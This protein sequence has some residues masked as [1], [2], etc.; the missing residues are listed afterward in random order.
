MA[1]NIWL[2]AGGEGS[3]DRVRELVEQGTSP[4]AFDDNSYSPLHAAASWG[5]S[6][7]LRFLVS[8]GG[9]INLAD[10][11]G[12][13]PLYVVE[14]I[15]MAKLVV[16]LGAD[17]RHVNEEGLT[18][19]AVL[20]E[21]HPHIALYLRTLTGEPSPSSASAPLDPSAPAPAPGQPQPNLDAPTDALMQA[22]RAI[23]ERS[24]R[25]DISEQE[26]DD[27]LREV[28]EQAVGGQ[29]E[30]GRAIGEQ[31]SVDDEQAGGAHTR[32]RTAD[33]MAGEQGKPK[34]SRDQDDIG[35]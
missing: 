26:T 6:D 21:E 8:N 18:A 33:E 4:N 2:A 28:V 34:R 25:G 16:D 1:Q 15:A 3:L 14:S 17:P 20:Q 32:A 22:V 27:L 10:S 30:A 29:L 12:D 11:D 23:M 19:A 24:E 9:D 7:I 13:T 5:H 31:M 35:R